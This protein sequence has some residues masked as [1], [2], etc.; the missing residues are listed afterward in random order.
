MGTYTIKLKETT[1]VVEFFSIDSILYGCVMPN[2]QIFS[3]LPGFPR[4]QRQDE[5][6]DV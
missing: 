6:D 1:M 5:H 2:S 3:Y 4:L